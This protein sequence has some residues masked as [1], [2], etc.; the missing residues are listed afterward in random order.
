MDYCLSPYNELGRDTGWPSE[1]VLCDVTLREGEQTPG[2]AFSL[3]EKIELARRLDQAGCPR[4]RRGCPAGPRPPAWR[5]KRFAGWR[6]P[7]RRN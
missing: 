4:S 7:P 2:V 3:E 6:L 5:R 1:V